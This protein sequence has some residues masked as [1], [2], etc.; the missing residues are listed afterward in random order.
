M[1]SLLGDGERARDT[2]LFGAG[3]NGDV[4]ERELNAGEA[5][6]GLLGALPPPSAFNHGPDPERFPE[7]ADNTGDVAGCDSVFSGF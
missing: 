7:T 1:F 2:L 3:K 5:I 4:A 6:G